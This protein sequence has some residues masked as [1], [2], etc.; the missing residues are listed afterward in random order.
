MQ[1]VRFLCQLYKNLGAYAYLLFFQAN[2]LS[3]SRFRPCD[4][5]VRAGDSTGIINTLRNPHVHAS[6]IKTD[7]S[8]GTFA[9]PFKSASGTSFPKCFAML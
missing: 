8:P 6:H 2:H 3:L 4:T 9:A 1:P 5:P 7:L